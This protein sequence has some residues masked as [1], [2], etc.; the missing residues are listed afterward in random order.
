MCAFGSDQ[1]F[2]F[3]QFFNIKKVKKKLNLHYINTITKKSKKNNFLD[4]DSQRKKKTVKADSMLWLLLLTLFN[5]KIK[6]KIP[7]SKTHFCNL[8]ENIFNYEYYSN[9][10]PIF[11]KL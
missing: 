6:I 10:T 3:C 5:S 7:A 11:H 9:I 2:Y 8:V 4:K 1:G